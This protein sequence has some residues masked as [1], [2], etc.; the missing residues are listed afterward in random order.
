MERGER[1][2]KEPGHLVTCS[3]FLGGH[4]LFGNPRGT[5]SLSLSLFKRRE[6]SHQE[7]AGTACCCC[8]RNILH[9]AARVARWRGVRVNGTKGPKTFTPESENRRKNR[10]QTQAGSMGVWNVQVYWPYT[11]PTIQKSLTRC[12]GSLSGATI[13]AIFKTMF[14]PG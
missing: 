10:C 6:P 4:S 2:I 8:I 3:V 14:A 7:P 5:L 13:Q 12:Y 1:V 9:Q 11:G